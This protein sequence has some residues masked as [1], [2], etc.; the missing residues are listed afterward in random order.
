MTEQPT[1]GV[2]MKYFVPLLIVTIIN[3]IIILARHS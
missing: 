3:V 1:K 2:I